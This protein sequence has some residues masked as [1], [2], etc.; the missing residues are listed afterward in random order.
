VAVLHGLVMVAQ[1]LSPEIWQFTNE[2]GGNTANLKFYRPAGMFI[3]DAAG[4]AN[5][6]AFYQLMGFVPLLLAGFSKKT[7][8]ISGV[9]LLVSILVT[10][11]M[12]ATIAFLSGLVIAL[13]AISYVKNNLLLVINYLLLISVAIMILGGAFYIISGLNQGYQEHFERIIFGRAERSSEGRFSL[14][15][16]GVDVLLDHGALFWGVGPENFREVDAAGTDNQLHNDTLAFLVERGLIGVLGLVLFAGI[17][18]TSAV[19]IIQIFSKDPKRGRL[20]LVVLLAALTAAMIES[21][22]HQIFHTRELWLVL[23][24][25]EAVL[26]KMMTSENGINPTVQIMQEPAQEPHQM[27]V[28]PDTAMVG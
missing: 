9:F 22:T 26:Y 21:L 13:L 4:C 12:G 15:Q 18:M 20:E 10:G 19:R 17:A 11:S 3:C 8:L 7:T 16:R 28:Q 23:A 2:L 27:L 25:Q 1:F 24:V 5:K 14:W 6:A